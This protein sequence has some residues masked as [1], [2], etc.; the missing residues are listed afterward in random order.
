MKGIAV[1][2][3]ADVVNVDIEI[4][5]FFFNHFADRHYS[6]RTP[7][8]CSKQSDIVHGCTPNSAVGEFRFNKDFLNGKASTAA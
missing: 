8:R 2:R 7:W 3:E 6:G 5:G 1:S 4:A